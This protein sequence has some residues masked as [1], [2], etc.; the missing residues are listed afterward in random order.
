MYFEILRPFKN[1]RILLL[2]GPLGPFFRRF[3]EDLS[4]LNTQVIKVN[5]NAGDELF[6]SEGIIFTS[7]LS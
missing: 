3:A 1:K 4:R 5:F 2:Q 7:L 6:Y